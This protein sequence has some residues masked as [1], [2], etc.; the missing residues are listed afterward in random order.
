M[1]SERR[2]ICSPSQ[3][4]NRLPADITQVS[5]QP[6]PLWGIQCGLRIRAS[7]LLCQQDPRGWG[8]LSRTPGW[9]KAAPAASLS[10][11]PFPARVR[12]PRHDPP[13]FK[14]SK[15]PPGASF[16]A[17]PT[18]LQM[19]TLRPQVDWE[20]DHR[21]SRF[22]SRGLPSTPDHLSRTPMTPSAD[23]DAPRQ[24]YTS[25]ATHPSHS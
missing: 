13:R 16:P 3:A 15:H 8:Q 19:D 1:T 14:G 25:T 21:L 4:I 17:R 5:P 11:D 12:G 18:S 6:A 24:V 10:A 2:A 22:Q 20:R 7:W 23:S 9:G